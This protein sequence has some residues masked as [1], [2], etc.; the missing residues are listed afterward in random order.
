MKSRISQV[1]YG[2]GRDYGRARPPGA[3]R[4]KA[5][6]ASRPPAGRIHPVASLRFHSKRKPVAYV[7]LSRGVFASAIVPKL[8]LLSRAR[9]ARAAEDDRQGSAENVPR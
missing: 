8:K 3:P 2:V 7:I 6:H 9:G 4:H 5:A 1:C